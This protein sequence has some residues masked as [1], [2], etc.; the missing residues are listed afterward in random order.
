MPF[1]K[2]SI[3]EYAAQ[4][5]IYTCSVGNWIT[6]KPKSALQDVARALGRN[7]GTVMQL[8]TKLPDEFDDLTMDDHQG[9]FKN[10]ES[11]DPNIRADAHIE[12]AKYQLFYDFKAA[13]PDIVDYAFRIVGKIKA[14]GT[15]AGGIIIAD[16]P[17]EDIV[18]MSLMGPKGDKKWTSQWTE[19]RKT[20]LSKFGLVKFDILGVKTIYYIWQAGNLIKQNRGIDID[21]SK[22]NP[23]AE[24]P[25]IGHTVNNGVR[26][27]INMNDDKAL[28]QCNDQR[29]DSVFQIE[30]N[31][32]KQ[33]ISDAKVRGFS[34]LVAYNA[35]GR[36][37]PM[38]CC[39]Y[40]S[41]V[42]KIGDEKKQI[43]DLKPEIDG[44]LYKT[45]NGIKSTNNYKVF[46]SGKKKIYKVT[47]SNGKVIRITG[48]HKIFSENGVKK[49][50]D[51]K[52]G[53]KVYVKRK[54]C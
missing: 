46:N 48:N 3:K 2:P 24:V 13:N 9:Y 54:N 43:C 6:Y 11:P 28:Q 49:L 36:P 22:I 12:I 31:I 18:P 19:G 29:V 35:L 25:Y 44:I 10:L 38:E 32:Q 27:L 42:N 26:E 40:S 8:T 14:Q 23:K 5:Y 33:I 45:N 41:L 37:G 16:R 39:I 7:L 4:K 30:T 1:V 17:I 51:L 53:D 20:Q 15:H 47:L 52:V 50:D 34:D 21:W